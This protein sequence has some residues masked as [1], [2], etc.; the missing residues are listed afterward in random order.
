[1]AGS[2]IRFW[3]AANS[4]AVDGIWRWSGYGT[5]VN[6]NLP[7]ITTSDSN[8]QAYKNAVILDGRVSPYAWD[9]VTSNISANY[10][11]CR[12]DGTFQEQFCFH[13]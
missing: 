8:S 10:F 4:L 11:I 9:Y 3:I 13:F 6:F 7:W 12:K 5:N 1:L 2:G